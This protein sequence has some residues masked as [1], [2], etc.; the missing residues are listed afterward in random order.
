MYEP[1]SLLNVSRVLSP[2]VQALPHI[3]ESVSDFLMPATIDS[4][5][6]NDLTRVVKAHGDSRAWTVAA[7]DGAAARGR[8]DIMQ[9]LHDT[10]SE[11][12]STEAC[13][14][15]ATNGYLEVVKWLHELYPDFC[16]PV[17]AMTVAAENDHAPVVRFLR[18]S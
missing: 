16:R 18:T 14:A 15:A 4:A 12:C 11:G 8:L 10:R 6:F 3:V 1:K 17:E 7:M 5:V 9:W 13:M 2:E